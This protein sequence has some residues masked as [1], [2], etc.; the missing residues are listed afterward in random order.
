MQ[1][2]RSTGRCNG[3]ARRA[4]YGTVQ[5]RWR[6]AD[7]PTEGPGAISMGSISLLVLERQEGD[8]AEVNLR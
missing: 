1:E 5:H 2:Q 3:S 8:N 4:L 6:S 7:R